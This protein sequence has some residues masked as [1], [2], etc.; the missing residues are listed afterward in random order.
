MSAAIRR[1]LSGN[2]YICWRNTGGWREKGGR[3]GERSWVQSSSCLQRALGKPHRAEH[4]STCRAGWPQSCCS[5]C[6]GLHA[7]ARALPH[8]VPYR[9]ASTS[10]R[11]NRRHLGSCEGQ[12]LLF[13]LL[14]VRSHEQAGPHALKPRPPQVGGGP[15]LREPQEIQRRAIGFASAESRATL[16]C[17]VEHRPAA[18]RILPGLRSVDEISPRR[19]PNDSHADSGLI[20]RCKS[21][22][23]RPGN[24]L[25][26]VAADS[27]RVG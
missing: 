10:P 17:T 22:L 14:P 8:T 24:E 4:R 20:E 3:R 9:D 21:A 13:D 25:L 23:W 6:F 12:P 15:V 26:A 19:S 2:W 16:R 5:E 7:V 1:C 18:R 27:W 11:Q